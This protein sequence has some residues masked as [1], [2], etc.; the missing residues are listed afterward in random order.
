MKYVRS[1]KA[2]QR[3]DTTAIFSGLFKHLHKE[4]FHSVVKATLSPNFITSRGAYATKQK[5][6]YTISIES[7]RIEVIKR[8]RILLR[9]ECIRPVL[10][11]NHF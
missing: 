8:E 6:Y 4:S 11:R 7:E 9:R 1:G 5:I 10:R 3:R 2:S